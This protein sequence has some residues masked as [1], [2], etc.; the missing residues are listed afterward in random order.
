MWESPIWELKTSLLTILLQSHP[1]Q[2][3][4]YHINQRQTFKYLGGQRFPFC[5]LTP[6][7]V[8]FS[9][10]WIKLY[11]QKFFI[12]IYILKLWI[13]K[14]NISA[15]SKCYRG[16]HNERILMICYFCPWDKNYSLM[17]EHWSNIQQALHSTSG[18]AKRKRTHTH[19]HKGL[20]L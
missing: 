18:T 5:S 16:Q 7:Q 17:V 15:I 4:I 3:K 9:Y 11:F 6:F 14:N 13:K 1:K 10:F 12:P 2:S 19:T 8:F 20:R